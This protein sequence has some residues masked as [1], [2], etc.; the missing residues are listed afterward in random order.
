MKKIFQ[1]IFL[2]GVI[3]TSNNLSAQYKISEMVV[4]KPGILTKGIS[5]DDTLQKVISVLGKPVKIENVYY[6]IEQTYGKICY[7]NNS[8]IYILHGKVLC[9]EISDNSLAF[10]KKNK[11]QI[12]IGDQIQNEGQK[13]SKS[14]KEV[15]RIG[16]FIDTDIVKDEG[17]S[18]D[19][20]Y[21]SYISS[22]YFLDDN[23]KRYDTVL[24]EI[25]LNENKVVSIFLGEPV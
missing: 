16:D 21:T 17:T 12:T 1:I 5:Y 6:R 14:K 13:K 2:L 19:V 22:E 23:D 10:G 4:M 15:E 11:F 24:F 25:L 8:K 7:Y 18:R 9:F 20:N 3:A